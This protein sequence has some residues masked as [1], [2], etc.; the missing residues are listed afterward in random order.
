MEDDYHDVEG[1]QSGSDENSGGNDGHSDCGITTDGCSDISGNNDDSQSCAEEEGGFSNASDEMSNHGKEGHD[2]DSD[3]DPSD[4]EAEGF[5]DNKVR[6]CL[7]F[8]LQYVPIHN[9]SKEVIKPGYTIHN[10]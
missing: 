4:A 2:S 5:I 10:H 6:W 7:F 1:S 9:T 8:C 3:D